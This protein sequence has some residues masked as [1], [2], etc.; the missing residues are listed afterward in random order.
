M[1]TSVVLDPY[2]HATQKDPWDVFAALRSEHPVYHDPDD[3]FWALS[4]YE[5]V[6]AASFDTESFSN[7]GGI[8]LGTDISMAPPSMVLMDPPR[9]TQLRNL[10]SRAWTPRRIAAYEEALR[11]SV[12]EFIDAF[13]ELEEVDLVPAFA[14]MVPIR[15]ISDIIGVPSGDRVQFRQ[16]ADVMLTDPMSPDGMASMLNCITYFR[17][18]LE[19]RQRQPQDDFMSG[20]LEAQVDGERLSLEEQLG[21]ILLLFLAGIETTQFHFSNACYELAT[22]PDVQR[23]LRADPTLIPSATEEILRYDP[24]VYGDIRTLK[25]EVT[26]HGTTV[27]VGAVVYLLFGAANHDPDVFPDPET[28]DIRRTP[29]PH[30]SFASGAHFCLG[31][32]L[33]RMESRVAFEELLRRT[34]T[35]E[36]V[37]DGC[38][39][40]HTVGPFMRGMD[41]V[42][43]SFGARS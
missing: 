13:E 24:P 35:F 12:N 42:R 43:V 9:H 28:L 10:V 6:K 8:I 37:P 39:F 34:P 29:N 2:D 41:E 40:K 17:E 1:K 14:K 30:L 22:R 3:R 7:E 11:A 15:A 36:A 19:A 5:D 26:L 23:E 4:R 21:M 16:W 33:V 25:R 31:A 38:R 32:P 20:M 18:A 27:P